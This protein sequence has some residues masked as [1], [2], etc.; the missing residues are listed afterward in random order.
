M[1]ICPLCKTQNSNTL[2][3]KSENREY[4][5][6]HNCDLVFVPKKF[7]I[8][9]EDEKK[10]Y[11]FHQNSL[12]NIG[13]VK[14]LNRLLMPLQRHL[15][16]EAKGLDF[17]SGP[18]PT[19]CTIMRNNGYHMD[20]YDYFYAPNNEVFQ[21]KYDFITSTEVIEHLHYPLD[22][23]KRLWDCLLPEGILGL[24]TA[25]RVEDFETWYYKRDLTHICF[26][27]YDTFVWI[28]KYFNAKLI[29]PQD[30][31]VLLKKTPSQE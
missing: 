5:H 9:K 3:H 18:G 8:S 20:I 31:V 4:Y 6:C 22:E 17:G 23:L 2:F 11:D 10:K 14:F 1:I 30:G 21:K 16:L 25:F 19:L 13:Y 28:A 7:F 27:S 24:M 26:Y 15:K 29:V 12:E